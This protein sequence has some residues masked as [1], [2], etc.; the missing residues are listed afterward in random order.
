MKKTFKT[1]REDK[2]SLIGA[3]LSFYALIS[4]APLLVTM[5]L[6]A[7]FL[8]GEGFVQEQLTQQIENLLGSETTELV[9]NMI[10]NEQERNQNIVAATV[11]IVLLLFGATNVFF[12]LKESLNNIWHIERKKSDQSIVFRVLNLVRRYILSGIF[13]F[14]FGAVF[15]LAL[16]IDVVVAELINSFQIDF[17]WL[18]IMLEIMGVIASIVILTIICAL[19]FKYLPDIEIKFRDV[20]LGAFVTAILFT[21]GQWLIDLYLSY[22]SVTSA[23]GAAGALAIL[24]LWVYYSMQILIIGAEFTQ[25]YS[26]ERQHRDNIGSLTEKE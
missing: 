8:F 16:V 17:I 21:L 15:V 1:W 20:R 24:L 12:Q 5:I 19:I 3:G 23:Y 18:D 7:G 13:V 4:L 22:V 26:H 9:A 6:L 10:K 2:A 25:V 14:G 11:S